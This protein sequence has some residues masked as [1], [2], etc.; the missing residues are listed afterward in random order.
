MKQY[1]CGNSHCRILTVVLTVLVT[2]FCILY[3]PEQASSDTPNEPP[4]I[5]I[6][7]DPLVKASSYPRTESEYVP[8]EIIVK[9]KPAASAD[10]IASV[11][12]I[13]SA[14]LLYTSPHA[15]YSLIS[16]PLDK[17]VQEMV[18][19]YSQ[20]PNVEYAEPN[21]ITHAHWTPNDPY[22]DPYQWHLDNSV[23]GGINME[24]A[25]EFLGAPGN[26][27]TGV[28]VAVLDS[29][30]AYENYGAYCRAPDLAG[31]CFV[32]GYDFI[33]DDAHPND[34]HGHGTHVT[35][36]IAQSTNNG[37][38]VAGVAFDACIMPIKVFNAAGSGTHADFSDGVHYAVDHG[39]DIINYSGG[40]NTSSTTMENA[41]AYAYEHGVT[42]IASAGNEKEEGNLP[43]YPAAYD[44]YVI[45]VGATRY[46]EARAPYSN[47]GSYLD[48]AA[49]GG[50]VTVDQNS[51]GYGDGIVQQTINLETKDPCDFGYYFM[52]GT[53]MAAPHVSGVAALLVAHGITGPDN[54]RQALE[55]TAEDHGTAGWDEEYGWGIVDAYAALNYVSKTLTI[56]TSNG[57]TVTNPGIGSFGPYVLGQVI[58]ISTSPNSCYYFVNWS[59]DTSTIANASAPSTT[60]TMND[61]YS[62]TANFA[63]TSATYNLTINSSEYGNVSIPG[64]GPSGPYACGSSV[65]LSAI[66]DSCC[67]FVNWTGDIDSIANPNAAST[68]ILMNGSKTI[69]ANFI[70]TPW[71]V[72]CEGAINVLD[73]I[74]IGQHWGQTGAPGWIPEDVNGDGTVNVL[75]MILVGQ[76][77]TG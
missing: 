33:N 36:T 32:S 70:V 58:N 7:L 18:E 66:A 53:S 77:W 61:S 20:N 31:T 63:P 39:A 51:D 41:C 13:C 15:S 69:Q 76:H 46:D 56:S 9:F 65:N 11:N 40:G 55:S 62:I 38:G 42:I 27:G 68:T 74:L 1:L 26:P 29:G 28:I 67:G 71:D 6:P 23:Y 17:T 72:N 25:W 34:D 14:S 10:E 4:T 37:I 73:M 52:E 47:T 64:E 75:D 2:V 59:G 45:A 12:S 54:I 60:I 22:Y 35:G 16:V 8:G 43:S 50:D 48:I 24:A 30:I 57:G 44:D 3:I 19:L 5:P 21:Y 49:P